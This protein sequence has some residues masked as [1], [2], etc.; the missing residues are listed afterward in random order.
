MKNSDTPPP[1][2]KGFGPSVPVNA[3]CSGT[4]NVSFHTTE[5]NVPPVLSFSCVPPTAVTSGSVDGQPVVGVV[6]RVE[7]SSSALL[8]P[9]SPVAA[10]TV[11]PCRNASSYAARNGASCAKLV[12]VSSVASKLW[13]ITSPR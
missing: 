10:R 5:E 3:S 1:V 4:L 13:L 12:N 9:S 11:T 7:P 8:A 6:N 2:A